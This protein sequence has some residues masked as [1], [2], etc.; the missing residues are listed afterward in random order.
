MRFKALTAAVI[1]FTL[2]VFS[3]NYFPLNVG[4]KWYYSS[5][6][7]FGD[8]KLTNSI[9]S[10]TT[11][12][13]IHY[14]K[15][16]SVG[17]NLDGSA[18]DTSI[19]WMYISGKDVY[20]VIDLSAPD[21]K[22]VIAKLSYTAG[23]TIY[24]GTDTGSILLTATPGGSVTVPAK[25]YTNTW[26][27]SGSSNVM[28]LEVSSANYFADGA[29]LIKSDQTLMGV[30]VSMKLDSLKITGSPVIRLLSTHGKYN[31]ITA[32]K[33]GITIHSS[34]NKSTVSVFSINGKRIL[35]KEIQAN[36][37]VS[38]ALIGL[39]MRSGQYILSAEGVGTVNLIL[40]VK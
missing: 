13:N 10:D 3:E 29:G 6:S 27:L 32:D 24:T 35:K 30:T 36:V 8:F 19:S 15:F 38:Y 2:N 9:P 11:V 37:P 16:L 33:N 12:G 14:Y 7:A 31:L 25:T 34:F 1:L 39:G 5:T 22:Y 26:K 18:N 28:G 21:E 20:E 4:N 23:D 17:D 40:P